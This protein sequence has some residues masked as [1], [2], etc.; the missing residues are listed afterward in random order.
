MTA[1]LRAYARLAGVLLIVTFAAG[2]FGESY[3]PSLLLVSGDAAATVGK[4]HA[5][6]G[7]FRWSFAAYLVEALCDTALSALFYILLRPVGRAAALFAAFLGVISTAT[8]A[9]NELF[10][11]VLPS[12]LVR[13]GTMAV[14]TPPQVDALVLLSMRLYSLGA[15]VFMTF[16][17]VA[18]LVRAGLFLRSRAIPWPIGALLVLTGA[19]F[20]ASSLGAI[21]GAPVPGVTY[22]MMPGLILLSLWLLVRG[23]DVS[24]LAG[25]ATAE[26]A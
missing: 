25:G 15:T 24:R 17:G 7:L 2:G 21:F 18:W 4:I 11:F 22:A 3:A 23:V 13:G 6:N 26:S 19:G 12:L 16:Y 1:D 20:M 14:F 5:L 10:F 9:A 8:F